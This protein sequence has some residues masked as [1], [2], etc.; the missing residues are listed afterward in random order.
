MLVDPFGDRLVA[1]DSPKEDQGRVE[2]LVEACDPSEAAEFGYTINGILVSDFY[3]P[4]F[5]DPL[6]APAVRYSF[7][8]AIQQPRQVLRGGYLSWHDPSS[9]EWWQEIWF[10]GP[11]PTFRSLGCLNARDGSFRSQIDRLTT[12][13]TSEAQA[14]GL[15][16]A[17]A[18]GLAAGS[19]EHVTV[20]RAAN[21]RRQI[22]T[23]I[24]GSPAKHIADSRRTKAHQKT[25]HGQHHVETERLSA[26]AG[27]NG[28][29]SVQGLRVAPSL[30]SNA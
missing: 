3:S 13:A 10:G 27:S 17:R 15:R 24:G 5:F 6:E 16:A 1:S 26:A 19:I 4:R 12:Q 28:S 9:N 8:G 22:D 29:T 11:A 23:L 25:K 30:W 18:A 2:I 20:A 14:N 7:T 21:L